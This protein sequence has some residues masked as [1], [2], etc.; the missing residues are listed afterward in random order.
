MKTLEVKLKVDGVEKKFHL[1]L[2]AGGQKNLK[3]KYDENM[4]ATLMSAVD[5]IDRAVDILDA[6]LNYAQR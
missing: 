5:D 4:L 6:S 1:R 2:T 3:E